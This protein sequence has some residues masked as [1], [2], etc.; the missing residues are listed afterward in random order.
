MVTAVVVLVCNNRINESKKSAI[1]SGANEEHRRTL[2]R[3]RSTQV[4]PM[5]GRAVYENERESKI[6]APKT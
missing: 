3:P 6:V 2:N 4:F 1:L 5:W